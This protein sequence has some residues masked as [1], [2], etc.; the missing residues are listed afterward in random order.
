MFFSLPLDGG[1]RLPQSVQKINEPIAAILL[2]FG[3]VTCQSYNA[4]W[5][6][7]TRP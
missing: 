1:R 4:K 5:K 7:E 2:L 6:I 3:C